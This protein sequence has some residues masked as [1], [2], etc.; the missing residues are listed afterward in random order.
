MIIKIIEHYYECL[1]I[2]IKIMFLHTRKYQDQLL[3]TSQEW[4]D[5]VLYSIH[6]DTFLFLPNSLLMY[7]IKYLTPHILQAKLRVNS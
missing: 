5:S 2:D 3:N 7:V 4:Y 6:K 1:H